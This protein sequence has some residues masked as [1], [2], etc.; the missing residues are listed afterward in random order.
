MK[1]L[2]AIKDDCFVKPYRKRFHVRFVEDLPFDHELY[3]SF[4]GYNTALSF[5]RGL[6]Q[7][8]LGG[9]SELRLSKDSKDFFC[10]GINAGYLLYK[11]FGIENISPFIQ[12]M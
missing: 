6:V 7:Y 2:P 4:C 3:F 8:K 10:R 9:M 5:M 1:E 11:S 12:E